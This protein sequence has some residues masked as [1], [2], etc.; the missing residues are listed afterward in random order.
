MKTAPLDFAPERV[1][2]LCSVERII[3]IQILYV[4]ENYP[5]MPHRHFR[6]VKRFNLPQAAGRGKKKKLFVGV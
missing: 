3:T 2:C 6:F 1:V 4:N 5:A